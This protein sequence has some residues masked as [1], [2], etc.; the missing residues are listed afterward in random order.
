MNKVLDVKTIAINAMIAAVYA[1][2]TIAIAPIAYGGIQMRISEIMVFLAFYNRK[3]IPGLVIGCFAA[4]MASPMAAWDMIFGTFATL[5]ACISMYKLNNLYL[6]ALAGGIINGLIVGA[7][8]YYALNLPF[9][10]NA[11]YVF[12][13][14]FAVL[15]VGAFLFKLLEKNEILMKKYILE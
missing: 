4:N 8:L 10:I 15:V 11:F 1:A 7:E 14:E 5:L 3:Y 6:G 2:M 13:G 12:I 9:I